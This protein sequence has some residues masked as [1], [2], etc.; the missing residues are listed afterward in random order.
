VVDIERP[1]SNPIIAKS[2]P[3]CESERPL[4]TSNCVDLAQ[5]KGRYDG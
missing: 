4:P 1:A 3:L 2:G 5:S